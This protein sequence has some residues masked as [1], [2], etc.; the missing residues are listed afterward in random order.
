MRDATDAPREPIE[1]ELESDDAVSAETPDSVV[2]GNPD[3]EEPDWEESER[4]DDLERKAVPAH[5]TEGDEVEKRG[6]P[7]ASPVS[8]SSEREL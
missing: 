2:D 8:E 5:A 7:G 4:A 6:D 3:S 1:V